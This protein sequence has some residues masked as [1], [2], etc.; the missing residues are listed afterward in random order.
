MAAITINKVNKFYGSTQVL[1][2]NTFEIED[3]EFVVLVGPSGC[4]KTTLLRM[5]A[6][7]ETISSGEIQIGGKVVNH[8]KPRDRGIAMVFQSYA[9]YPH[10]SVYE[11][12]A[13]SQSLKKI[14]KPT[15]QSK[16]EKVAKTLNIRNFLKRRPR[17]LSGG[18]RQRVAMGRAIIRDP[19]AFLFD[20]PLS[21][22]DAALR[23]QMRTEI[24]TLHQ[25]LQSTSV[26]VTHDQIEAMTMADRIVVLRDG[27]VEQIG[28]PLT[29]YDEPINTFVAGFIGSPP[30]NYFN[31]VIDKKDDKI[32]LNTDDGIP[33]PIQPGYE[34][35]KGVGVIYGIR[36]QFLFL[37]SSDHGIDAT[38]KVIE[39]TGAETLVF[40][41]MGN[42][43]ICLQLMQ[44]PDLK[45]GDSFRFVPDTQHVHLFDPITQQRIKRDNGSL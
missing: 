36:P 8:L 9:L 24:K 38:V 44:R 42:E 25:R 26:Y 40:A 5:I 29:L 32:C 31:G 7:L 10:L 33:L 34:L 14:D 30:I 11:N 21:N 15:I 22:L 43:E 23:L 2:N 4:G 12:I 35:E 20:E 18:Q 19:K 37:D 41:Q 28:P 16:V 13:F 6:G 27:K 3:G 17:Q 45:P 39:P 1:Y